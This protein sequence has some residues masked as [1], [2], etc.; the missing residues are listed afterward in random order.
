[1]KKIFLQIL[2]SAITFNGTFAQQ[3][4]D[5]SII[6][7]IRQEGLERSK[8]MEHAFYLTDVN[9]PRLAN[10]PGARRSEQWAVNTLKSWGLQNVNLELWGEFG[11]G[12]DIQRCYVAM[13]TPYYQPLIATP[14]AWTGSTK[15]EISSDVV[16]IKYDTTEIK[17]LAGK[18]AGKIVIFD[19]KDTIVTTYKSDATRFT[20][21][22]L[23][24]IESL[25]VLKKI[26]P[27]VTARI[28]AVRARVGELLY[29]QN[30]GLVLTLARGK[31]GTVFNAASASYEMDAKPAAAELEM[32]A[33]NYLRI[34]R[35][36]KAG[37][38]VEI[39][40]DIRTT[41]YK[42]N[43]KGYNVIAEIP[44][45]D[46]KLKN[47]VVML[48]AHLD[49]WHGATGATDNAS[50]CAVMME[51]I[52]II[53]ALNLN[54]RRTIRL[55]LWTSEEQGLWG[56]KGYV[57]DHYGDAATMKL[58]PE[59]KN[60]SAYY[61]LDNGAGKVRGIYLQNNLAVKPIFQ[62]WLKP[63]HD[64]GATAV[65][66]RNTGSTDHISFDAIGIPG[67]Q[68]IQDKLEYFTRT[69][70]SNQDTYERLNEADLK[71][72]ATVIAA[73]VYNTAQLDQKLPRKPLAGAQ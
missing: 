23:S 55:A 14:R 61:N 36:L 56:S 52:R 43:P 67:F 12:W 35:L 18:L 2:V 34:V 3:K 15:G 13:K 17:R 44:G 4:P 51:A 73:F 49:S 50:G 6:Q 24:G 31:H 60:I 38:K 45:T 71:Q 65:P 1:M 37:T 9:G 41:F 26:S 63:F 69:H 30:V 70:H 57:A 20:D 59:Q 40:A 64:L 16:L 22:E 68:F 39:E 29:E 8:V 5:P 25:P 28:K 27:A 53:K 66:D 58:K 46:K 7:Q 33:E 72:A 11:Q 21:E 32:S 48:G 62:E 42:E 47:E 10:S 54:P 19:T